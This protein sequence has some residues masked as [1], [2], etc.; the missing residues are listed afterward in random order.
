MLP[1]LIELCYRKGIRDAV[2]CPGSRSAP[3]TLAFAR[4]GKI[5]CR[6]ISDE[7]SAAFMALGI[8]QASKQPVALVCTSGSAAY[9]FAPAV[10][11]A[12]FQQIP[13]VVFTAD[14]PAEWIDQLDGQTIRQGE[15][16]G[17]HVKKY[18]ELPQDYVHPDARWHAN[19]II[20]D[21][22]NL[23]TSD[24]QGPV[25]VNAPFREPLYNIDPPSNTL[26]R[27]VD[28]WHPH[29]SLTDAS[30][31]ELVSE[32]KS[33]RR[34]L[35]VAGQ[36]DYDAPLLKTLRQLHEHTSWVMAGDILSNLHGLSFFCRSTDAFLGQL[37]TA[38]KSTLQ[39][40]L[41]ITFGKSVIAKNL[42]LFLRAYPAKQH[43]HLQAQGE[44]ADTFQ[45]LNR[46]IPVAANVFFQHL[47]HQT[48]PKAD[49]AYE[50]QWTSFETLART[51]IKRFL[52]KQDGGE[53]KLIYQVMT[54]LPKGCHLH[55][56]NS[57]SVR[58]ANHIGLSADREDTVVYANRGTSGIDGCTSTATGHAWV[59]KAPVVLI[60]G[61][62]AFFYDRNAFW[63]K[64]ATPNLRVVLINNHGGIIFNLIDGPARQPEAPEFFITEQ[65]LNARSL[66]REFNL[67]YYDASTALSTYFGA[68]EQASILEI[69]GSQDVNKKIFE[70]FRHNLKQTYGA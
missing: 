62:L 1:Q 28:K 38:D 57:M 8:A 27:V 66:A 49:K 61:D 64:Y 36:Q 7:R 37:T 22:I 60:T 50:E 5:R 55:L 20:N 3:L 19:R 29:S 17:K 14:R 59:T 18:F 68:S 43:W 58:Y 34:I 26:V 11:E 13:L 15:L 70:E 51:T 56:A 54:N 2:L 39:P 25:H 33:F 40:D 31:Q 16:Y 24:N 42:K 10:A 47:L 65:K 4:H 32:L 63:H 67:A 21:A 9:N 41:L 30:L 52:D 45:Q 69:E 48:I 46:I 35:I 6:T 53:F 44:S 23:A 12:F